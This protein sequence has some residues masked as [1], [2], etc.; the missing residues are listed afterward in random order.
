[1]NPKRVEQNWSRTAT[2][3]FDDL[4]GRGALCKQ[5]PSARWVQRSIVCRDEA[6]FTRD[7][8]CKHTGGIAEPQRDADQNVTRQAILFGLC[9]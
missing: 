8:S 7:V 4:G 3:L 5:I 1:M 6:E 9:R 2:A